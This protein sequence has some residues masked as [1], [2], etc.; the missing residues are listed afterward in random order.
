METAALARY[1]RQLLERMLRHARDTVP[2]YR[3]RLDP[4]FDGSDRFRMEAW[5]ALPLLTRTDI[6]RDN[7]AFHM[8][9][10]PPE[11][12]PVVWSQTMGTTGTPLGIPRTRLSQMVAACF[13]ER[14]S[15][16]HAID[17]R[18]PLG[19]IRFVSGPEAD[20][21]EGNTQ[22][23]WSY[24]NPGAHLH[25]L[26]VRTTVD[27]QIDWLYRRRPAYL[28][29]YPSIAA[30]IAAQI[31]R[32]GQAIGLRKVFTFG[33]TVSPEQRSIVKA[34]FGADLIDTYSAS[35]VG[36]IAV[37]CPATESYHI[38]AEGNFVEVLDEAGAPA[39]PGAPGR[40]V[41]TPIYNTAMP[42]VRYDIG[43]YAET[44]DE[45]CRCGRSLPRLRRIMGRSRHVFRFADG[46]VR[47]PNIH[48]GDLMAIVPLREF[49]VVQH[50]PSDIELRFE[51]IAGREEAVD[52]DALA[53][54]AKRDLHSSVSIRVTEMPTIPRTPGGK[55]E[56]YLSHV[57]PDHGAPRGVSGREA[58]A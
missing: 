29:L 44:L 17:S 18:L 15:R 4:V 27:Q 40:V 7:E 24:A 1:Q 14:R 58:G 23:G 3:T 51:R 50:S 30:E 46:S 31:G 32:D 33:E 21:P 45:P 26:S 22:K 55:F 6:S 20:F 49:Q 38:M 39:A 53:A 36:T 12:Q 2:A 16:W 25:S 10:I 13:V 42:L 34:A 5:R 28:Q 56:R 43:D 54:L 52:H 9:A 47:W 8:P 48:T 35:E 57:G 41:V 19:I 37:Q 11:L